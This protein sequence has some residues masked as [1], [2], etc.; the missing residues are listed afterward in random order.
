MDYGY[1]CHIPPRGLAPEIL[2]VT[3]HTVSC[4][5]FSGWTQDA[6][7]DSKVLGDD[8]TTRVTELDWSTTWPAKSPK[9]MAKLEGNRKTV[10]L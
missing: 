3:Y 5:C 7:E 9:S 2:P 1:K 8:R 10:G 6:V 4:L